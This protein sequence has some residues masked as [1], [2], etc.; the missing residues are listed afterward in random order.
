MK[1][2]QKIRH[3][4]NYILY[5]MH[6]NNYRPVVNLKI[7]KNIQ[8]NHIQSIHNYPSMDFDI[9]YFVSKNT[10]SETKNINEEK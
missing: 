6:K 3:S 10:S 4:I 9:L 7:D 1:N 5:N 8:K 2:V